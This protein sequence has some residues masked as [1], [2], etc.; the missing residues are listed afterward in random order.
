ML[1]HDLIAHLAIIAA[2]LFAG[3]AFYVSFAEQPA[4]MTLDDA[5]AHAHWGPSYARGKIM[6]GAL[7]AIGA[8]LAF[9]VWWTSL[10]SLWLV[11]ALLLAAN[12]PFT[13]LVIMPVNRKLEASASGQGDAGTRALLHRWGRLHAIRSALGAASALVMLAAL[14]NRL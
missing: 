5:A 1:A 4:R 7:A 8:G 3:A 6:Q 11:G 2:A 14:H 9:Y 10:N 12:W 13:L